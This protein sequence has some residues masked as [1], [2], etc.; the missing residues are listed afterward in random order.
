MDV[1]IRSISRWLDELRAA[2]VL[3]S[4]RIAR[5]NIYIIHRPILDSAIID[6]TIIDPT[7]IDRTI[8]DPT[9][10][11]PRVHVHY[12]NQINS[13][14]H[15]NE[16]NSPNSE[17]PIMDR[18][19]GGG[20][21][22]HDLVKDSPTSTKRAKA[23]QPCYTA[24]GRFLAASGFGSAKEFDDSALDSEHWIAYVKYQLDAGMDRGRIVHF[25]R[26]HAPLEWIAPSIATSQEPTSQED[27]PAEAWRL[28]LSA[29]TIEETEARRILRENRK[30]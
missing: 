5:R 8:I 10:I 17:N 28:G 6:P 13:L 7:I 24:L 30:K 11:D 21:D 4:K 20:G 9:I 27:P 3:T 14:T 25:L 1:D 29:P 15:T 26:M 12:S 16:P 2:S 18:R 23:A 19:G 22:H